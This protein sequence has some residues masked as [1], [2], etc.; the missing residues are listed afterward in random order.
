MERI[1]V[2]MKKYVLLLL[3]P[4][5]A[6]SMAHKFYV[7][8]TNVNYSEKDDA[9]QVT[10][11][12]FIDDLEAVIKERYGI[13]SYLATAQETPMV[14]EYIEKYL[15]T[16]FLVY[17]NGEQVAYNFLGKKYDN[18]VVICYIELPNV[19]LGTLKTMEFENE[20]LTDLFDEQKNIV[21]VKWQGNKRSFI[22]I[23]SNAKGMLNF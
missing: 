9:F 11:R 20:I 10:T 8:V 12:I 3:L 5:L 19:G 2:K 17:L 7:S 16:K 22:M 15:R 1:G 18:D 23:K 4:L 6:F 21:H 13:A 14:D